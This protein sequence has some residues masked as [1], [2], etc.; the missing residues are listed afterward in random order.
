MSIMTNLFG[1]SDYDA[2]AAWIGEGE[3]V[4]DLGCG[5][6]SLLMFLRTEKDV[7]GYGVEIDPAKVL[8]CVKNQVNVIQIDLERG[9]AGFEDGF[10]DHVIMSQSLQAVHRTGP[11][12]QEMLRVGREAVVSFPN[13]GY[14]RHREAIARGHM[15]V[16]DALPYQWY[17]TP[18]VRFFT[19]ADFEDLCATLGIEVR[20][21]LAFDGGKP[22]LEDP[23]LNA[24]LAVCRIGRI[25]A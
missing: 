2:I 22:V 15:P 8:A 24:S 18:N 16:S 14:R 6:G 13:F 5:D 17:N 4:L 1:R 11:L 25:G 3:S 7:R 23:N 20:G 19:L 21:L 9:L 10:F 12:L